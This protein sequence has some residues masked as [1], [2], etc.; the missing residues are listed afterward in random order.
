MELLLVESTDRLDGASLDLLALRIPDLRVEIF[1][2]VHALLSVQDTGNQ[3]IIVIAEDLLNA[4][5]L[6]AMRFLQA[7]RQRGTPVVIGRTADLLPLCAAM[8]EG[9]AKAADARPSQPPAAARPAPAAPHATVHR[10]SER[11]T[12]ILLLLCD[13]LQNKQIARRLD[14]SVS[15]I[16]THVANVFR[17]IGATNRLDAICRFTE[18]RTERHPPSE[19]APLARPGQWSTPRLS[20]WAA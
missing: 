13:G 6:Y 19:P 14:L 2:S 3:T 1:E 10:L 8:A 4:E 5:S 11:E 9:A 17:K 16:K 18:F 20:R 15:T 12:E 7:R